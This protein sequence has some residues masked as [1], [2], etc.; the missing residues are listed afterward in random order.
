LRVAF[1]LG[2]MSSLM[3]TRVSERVDG[4]KKR[5]GASNGLRK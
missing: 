5:A 3:V 1:S 2:M 4:L